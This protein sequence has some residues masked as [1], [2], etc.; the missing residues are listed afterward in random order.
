MTSPATPDISRIEDEVDFKDFTV[1]KKYI[2][3]KIGDDKFIAYARLGIPTIQALVAAAGTME[4]AQSEKDEKAFE[5][6]FTVFDEV[7]LPEHAKRF[8]ERAMSKGAET[9]DVQRELMPAIYYLLE[10]YGVRP[11]QPSSGSSSGSLSGTSG[12]TSTAGAPPE[13]SIQL[14]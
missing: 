1:A 5:G 7:L 8:R 3:F 10:C 12:T 11:T 13:T 14:T 9:I 6:L 4:K 2:G